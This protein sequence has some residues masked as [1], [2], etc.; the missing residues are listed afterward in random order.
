MVNAIVALGSTIISG[1][2]QWFQGKQEIA[3]AAQENRARLLRS[4][5]AHNHEWEMRQLENAGWKDDILFYAFIGLFV[6]AGFQ[7]DDA[8]QFFLNVDTMPDWFKQTWMW[9]VA[10]VLGV[11]KIGEMVPSLITGVKDALRK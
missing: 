8:G 2:T 5:Q 3:K 10:S 1:V 6:W 4:E 9:M 11:K 7:P